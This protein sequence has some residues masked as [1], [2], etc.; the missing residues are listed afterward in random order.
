MSLKLPVPK[1]KL[2]LAKRGL[3]TMTKAVTHKD[4][5]TKEETVI[6]ESSHTEPLLAAKNEAYVGISLGLTIPGPRNSYMVARVD[7]ACYL[8]CENNDDDIRETYKHAD[9]LIQE[10]LEEQVTEIKTTLGI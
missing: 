4:P 8:P 9:A 7:V 5:Q 3:L 1:L 10:V 2:P 6:D